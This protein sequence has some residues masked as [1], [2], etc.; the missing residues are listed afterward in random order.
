MAQD[1]RV[2]DGRVEDVRLLVVDDDPPIAD[3]VDRRA[4]VTH[5]RS[6]YGPPPYV[7]A[8]SVENP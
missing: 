1:G 4:A 7:E 2:E 5:R 6:P 8:A 3:L